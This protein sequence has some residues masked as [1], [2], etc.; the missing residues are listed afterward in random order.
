MPIMVSFKTAYDRTMTMRVCELHIS[1]ITA[2]PP[3]VCMT[4][5]VHT[6]QIVWSRDAKTNVTHSGLYRIT[7]S[8]CDGYV[9]FVLCPFQ[10]RILE[11]SIIFMYKPYK[12]A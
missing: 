10:F 8:E 5:A 6:H 1:N 9:F 12:W 11:C 3:L 2:K 7:K 4:P